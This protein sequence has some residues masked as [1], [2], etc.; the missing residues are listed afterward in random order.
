MMVVN[1]FIH[2]LDANK[3]IEPVFWFLCLQSNGNAISSDIKVV[4]DESTI[5][6]SQ[7]KK[8]KKKKKKEEKTKIRTKDKG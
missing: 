2:C 4:E 3:L 5:S 6:L 1:L 8:K 7:D